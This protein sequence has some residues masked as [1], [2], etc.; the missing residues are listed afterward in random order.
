MLSTTLVIIKLSVDNIVNSKRFNL[1]L[2]SLIRI[3]P[4]QG[5]QGASQILSKNRSKLFQL[6]ENK[7]I[8]HFFKK[9]IINENEYPQNT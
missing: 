6:S 3:I 2:V 8:N 4:P 7:S 1:T 5:M 9:Q